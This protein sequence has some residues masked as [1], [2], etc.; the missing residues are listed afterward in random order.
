MQL[1][2]GLRDAKARYRSTY[3]VGPHCVCLSEAHRGVIAQ[4]FRIEWKY[5]L[6]DN[7]TIVV[8]K[9]SSEQPDEAA[10]EALGQAKAASQ[11]MILETAVE[12]AEAEATKLRKERDEMKS[13]NELQEGQL[14][15]AQDEI[16]TLR[17]SLLK[18]EAAVD[19]AK[20][21]AKSGLDKCSIVEE[22]SKNN[23]ER[24]DRLMAE[25]DTL[26]EEIR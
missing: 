7:H 1:L 17:E 9:M 23:K 10:A 25:A 6:R 2:P 18:Q 11:Q 5:R 19:E 13:R 26:R 3:I 14:R 8:A 16:R 4:L 20:R 24:A 21:D 22:E 15:T 12:E